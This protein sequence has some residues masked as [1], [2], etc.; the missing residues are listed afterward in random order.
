VFDDNVLP[1]YSPFR[2]VAACLAWRRTTPELSW[3]LGYAF[4]LGLMAT[5][6]LVAVT[7]FWRNDWF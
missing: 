1:E 2:R 5:A 7:W 4:A 6:V 3:P